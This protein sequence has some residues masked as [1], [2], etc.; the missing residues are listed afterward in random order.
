MEGAVRIPW[1]LNI[2][3]KLITSRLPVP[4]RFWRRLDLFRHGA[5]DSEDYA[6]SVFARHHRAAMKAGGLP[7]EFVSLEI[8]PGDSLAGAFIAR[9]AGASRAIAIDGGRFAVE[10]VALYE[11]LVRSLGCEN[12]FAMRR[13][14]TFDEFLAAN[15]ISYLTQG[16]RSF[17][18]IPDGAVD[19]IWS[20]ATL[21]HI[22]RGEFRPMVGEMRRVLRSGGLMSHRVDLQDHLGGALN[23]LRFRGRLWEGPLARGASFYTNRLRRCDILATLAEAGFTTVVIETDRWHALPTPRRALAAEFAAYPEDE[24]LISGF[25]SVSRPAEGGE[26]RATP[27]SL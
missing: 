20:Q 10:D 1:W 22:P 17:A 2:S 9:A 4:Y 13:A 21:E 19:F 11:R 26:D 24:L 16:L 8:G 14:M 27:P 15:G 18:A 3:V 25:Q 23:N 7:A 5:M 6:R 12:R